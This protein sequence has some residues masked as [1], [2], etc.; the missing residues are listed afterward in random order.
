MQ[1]RAIWEYIYFGTALRYL[2]DARAGWKVGSTDEWYVRRNLEH[3]IEDLKKF[4]LPVSYQSTGDLHKI[5]GE[6]RAVDDD[7]ATLTAEQAAE[8]NQ[9]MLF[10]RKTLEAESRLSIAYIVTEK[11]LDVKKLVGNVAALMSQGVWAKLPDLARADLAEAGKCVAFELPTAS[12]FH[13]LRATE[14]VLR[15]FYRGVIK[16]KRLADP[17]WGPMVEQMRQKKSN[18]PD[19]TLL[20]VLDRIRVNFR[21][22]TN[23]PDAMYDIHEA[24]DVFLACLEAI[25]RMVRAPFWVDPA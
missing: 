4:D 1:S 20:D 8:L 9:E 12:A 24:Q 15:H 19:D 16:Q 14:G 23:H 5:L 6:L 3:F 18:R 21:N 10:V 17:M 13:S 7:D 2:Q 11:R 22:P 25:G